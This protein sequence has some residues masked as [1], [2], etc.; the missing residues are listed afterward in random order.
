[1]RGKQ[2]W[3]VGVPIL[4]SAG[5]LAGCG[6]ESAVDASATTAAPD[7]ATDPT[8]GSELDQSGGSNENPSD[9]PITTTTSDPATTTA[10]PA[11]TAA[12]TTSVAAPSDSQSLMI[13]GYGAAGGWN[14]VRWTAG[15]W[16]DHVGS[17]V[18]WEGSTA[19][20]ITI[21]GVQGNSTLQEAGEVCEPIFG[22]GTPTQPALD[23]VEG[24]PEIGIVA[25]WNPVPRTWDMLDTPPD[26]YLDTVKDLLSSRGL[27]PNGAVLDQ[28]VR[29]DLEGDGVD[30]ILISA[31]DTWD[32]TV[33]P[34]SE[35]YSLVL[36]RK[37]VLGEVQTAIL[38]FESHPDEG[39]YYFPRSR[40]A[41][42]ADLNGDAKME[43]LIQGDYYEGSA[44][45]AWE[46]V[47]DDLGPVQILSS[48]CGA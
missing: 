9:A 10:P 47:N 36:L 40:L 44:V 18:N 39:S 17:L 23:Y 31:N 3:L 43:I 8:V 30:E 13:F 48:G 34:H 12:P 37:V 4:L 25:D 24:Y 33:Q 16:N 7:T 1:M 21:D 22:Y 35:S 20:V 38:E 42:F 27:D 32:F 2:I 19:T 29:V 46:Y 11:T 26:V 5:L 28:V 15:D 45:F 6:S 14:G 41:G